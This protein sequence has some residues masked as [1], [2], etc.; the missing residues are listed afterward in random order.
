[1][2]NKFSKMNEYTKTSIIRV[3]KFVHIFFSVLLYAVCL[4][5][6]NS[7]YNDCGVGK[8]R[9]MIFVVLYTVVLGFCLRTYKAY[10]FGMTRLAMLIYSQTLSV[11]VAGGVSYVVFV[12]ANSALFTLL[13]LVVLLVTQFA[14]NVFCS[15]TMN[16]LYFAFNRTKKS[17]VFYRGKAELFRLNEIL[18]N[19][20][21]FSVS[22]TV[23]VCG[24]VPQELISKIKDNE[25]VFV[26]GIELELRNALLEYCVENA[27]RCYV[28]P[29][30]GDILM[31]GAK[32]MDMFYVPIFEV[33]RSVPNVEYA[34]IKRAVDIVCSL[35]GI[36]VLSPVMLI[37]ALAIKLYDAGPVIYKQV[38][39]TKNGKEFNIMKF[40]SMRVN[41]ESDGVARLASDNDN[42]ITPVGKVLRACRLDELPQ[43][44]NILK[45]DM[46]I[47]GPRPERPEIA[48]QYK[49]ILPAFDLRLQVK[50]GLTGLAQVYGRYNT[51]PYD[52]LQ[53]DL[54]YINRMS[55]AQDLKLVFATVKILFIKDSTQ[56]TGEGRITAVADDKRE[57]ILK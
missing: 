31:M 39:L 36:I 52:K 53:M 55:F 24:G 35:V 40:R 1:M 43:L 23:E 7:E 21:I 15:W 50:A 45:G 19:N 48:A 26:A 38:R 18:D 12:I 28:V 32:H 49:E 33:S 9:F 11:L 30:V 10:A 46:T 25:V 47:V 20:K 6:Y 29:A 3:C 44:F 14:L 56:G 42:R 17:I 5:F 41:A 4:E 8:T 54:M 2:K 27:V 16:K 13:P 37:V 34:V 22:E 57:N 51:E